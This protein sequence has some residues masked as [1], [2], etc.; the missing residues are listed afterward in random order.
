MTHGIMRKDTLAAIRNLAPRAF[1]MTFSSLWVLQIIFPFW[2]FWRDEPS[3]ATRLVVT[4]LSVMFVIAYGFT[5]FRTYFFRFSWTQPFRDHERWALRAATASIATVLVFWLGDAWAFLLIFTVIVAIMTGP[6]RDAFI[7]ALSS[8]VFA[9]VVMALAGVGATTLLIASAFGLVSG[10]LIASHL[11]HS[12]IV[13]EMVEARAAAERMAA[14]E[15]R[16]RIAQELHDVLGHSLSLITLK[17]EL[18]SALAEKDPARAQR[19]MREVEA[20]ARSAMAD[21][22]RTVAAERQPILSAELTDARHL[23]DAAGIS[24]AVNGND[25]DLPDD[26]AALFAWSVREGV[27]NVVRHSRAR[28]CTIS[29]MHDGER[30][31]LTVVDDG[32]GS[33]TPGTRAGSG[34]TGLSERSERMGGTLAFETLPDDSGHSLTVSVPDPSGV[35]R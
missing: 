27:T 5:F 35:M 21:V 26:V 6:P 2:E 30:A 24:L 9:I 7:S 11:R 10:I 4:A 23:L 32:A 14:A 19:E 16:L 20:L 28:R 18:A 34:L 3:L 31:I 12:G 13:G 33:D 29:L 22:R 25:G 8:L 1:L 15:E 17:S